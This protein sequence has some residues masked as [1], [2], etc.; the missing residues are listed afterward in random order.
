M[1]FFKVTNEPDDR[2]ERALDTGFVLHE[3][4]LRD[5]ALIMSVDEV[6]QYL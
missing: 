6:V 3:L 5:Q 2:C 1:V 4:V